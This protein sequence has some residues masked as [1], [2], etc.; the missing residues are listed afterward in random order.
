MLAAMTWITNSLEKPEPP[1]ERFCDTKIWMKECQKH[2]HVEHLKVNNTE[3]KH[4][5]VNETP[6]TPTCSPSNHFFNNEAPRKI[7]KN[8]FRSDK[9]RK[10]LNFASLSKE[11]Q[12]NKGLNFSW[13][14]D[15]NTEAGPQTRNKIFDW[16][17][18][19]DNESS[20][21]DI[22]DSKSVQF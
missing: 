5:R 16:S 14:R 21:E 19:R 2:I 22:E 20:V 11:V 6:R 8:S 7:K 10:K 9:A 1:Q 18:D 4:D 12:G 3:N 17:A 15:Q 13:T